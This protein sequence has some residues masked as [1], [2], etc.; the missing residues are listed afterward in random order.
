M[1]MYD[2]KTHNLELFVKESPNGGRDFS[3]SGANG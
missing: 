2:K 1:K 3:G